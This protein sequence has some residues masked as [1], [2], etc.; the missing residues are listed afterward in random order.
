M[1]RRAGRKTDYGTVVFHWLLVLLL[2]VSVATGLRI[3][4]VSPFDFA[5][6]H[7][8][9]ALLPQNMVWTA[10]IPAAIG[11]FG[12]ALAYVIYLRRAGL[13]RRVRIDRVRLKGLLGTAQARWSAINLLLNWIAFAALL[14]LL[15]TGALMYLGHG[16]IVV[17]LHRLGTWIVMVFPVAHVGTH[18]AI[19]GASQLMRIFRPTRLPP[20]P[21][22]DPLDVLLTVD[23]AASGLVPPEPAI[24]QR[25]TGR[26]VAPGPSR[27]AHRPTVL[28]A[29][30]FVVA[31]A[32][33]LIGMAMVSAVDETLMQPSLQIRKIGRADAPAIDG[34]LSD[35]VWQSARRVIVK[36]NQGANLGGDGE[37][38]VEIRAVHDG[39]TVYFAFVWDDPTRSLKHLPLVKKQDGWHVAQEGY[40]SGD[41]RAYFE[42]RF[43]VLFTRAN[44][45]L[46]GDRTFHAGRAPAAGKP[47]SMSGRGLH[48]TPDASIADV[49]L[50]GATTGLSG[51]CE[52]SHFGPP[53]EPSPLQIEGRAPYKGGFSPDPGRASHVPNFEPRGPGGYVLPVVPQWLPADW[54][55]IWTAMGRIHLHA[56]FGESEGARWAMSRTEA[57][58]YSPRLDAQ[59]PVGALIPGVV[60]V[61]DPEGD[62]AHVRCAARWAAGRWALE[63]ARR[64]DTGSPYDIAIE[65]GL[66]M[67]VA[68]FDRTQI[69]HTRH[70]RPIRIEVQ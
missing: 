57:V 58:P 40:D 28:Q 3:A 41:E 63:T 62:R 9:D 24:P 8:L 67:R 68:V 30:P 34:D 65:S 11:F 10:H 6:I 19:G 17:E 4:S 12:L 32:A 51:W 18:W 39:E 5:W 60:S 27:S 45:R 49:W 59:F 25:A 14:V 35:P 26:P 21:P 33:G 64:L 55:A 42:D 2:A 1:G 47:A 53:A 29:N 56:H 31:V 16:G 13:V 44:V 23:P 50:W 20:V 22:A 46:A 43:S 69:R 61:G 66:F 54:R 15:G 38:T 48:Y 36:T 37:S 52:D 70:V 7:A